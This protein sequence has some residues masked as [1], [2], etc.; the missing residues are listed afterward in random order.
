MSPQLAT[1]CPIATGLHRRA[2]QVLVFRLPTTQKCVS[3]T[4]RSKWSW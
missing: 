3:A 4:K 1:Y 2:R